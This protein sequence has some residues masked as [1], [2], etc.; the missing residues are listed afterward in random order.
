MCA[1]IALCNTD[2]DHV[3]VSNQS[4][5]LDFGS[6]DVD[7]SGWGE[8]WS[9]THV[10]WNTDEL[11]TTGRSWNHAADKPAATVA[12]GNLIDLGD[13]GRH[14]NNAVDTAAV[15]DGW[16]VEVWADVDDDKWEPLD[17]PPPLTSATKHD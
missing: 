6:T 13:E 9:E 16:D 5:R 12:D 7:W 11:T 15:G 1:A 14:G 2:V 3:V 8:D 17:T 10:D 4:Q